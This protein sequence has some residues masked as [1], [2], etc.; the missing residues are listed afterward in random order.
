VWE[1]VEVK[2]MTE[3]KWIEEKEFKRVLREHDRLANQKF[4]IHRTCP[5]K[6]GVKR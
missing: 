1:N 2:N 3:C 6:R 5:I 4:R